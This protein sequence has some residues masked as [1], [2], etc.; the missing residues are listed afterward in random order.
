MSFFSSS[1]APY[2][3][4][5]VAIFGFF[6]VFQKFEDLYGPNMTSLIGF[7]AFLSAGYS[8]FSLYATPHFPLTVLTSSVATALLLLVSFFAFKK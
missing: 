5:I 6:P 2:F 1:I 3:I 4:G 7:V 8:L